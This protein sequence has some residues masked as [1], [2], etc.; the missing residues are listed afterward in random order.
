M[1]RCQGCMSHCLQTLIGQST[2]LA[3]SSRASLRLGLKSSGPSPRRHA[4]SPTYR[5][6]D[7]GDGHPSTFRSSR[8]RVAHTLTKRREYSGSEDGEERRPRLPKAERE[9]GD[10][11]AFM[12]TQNRQEWLDSRGTT[13]PNKK[14]A[15]TELTEH[16]TARDAKRFLVRKILNKLA[17]PLQL[18]QYVRT[19]LAKEDLDHALEIVRTA[20]KDTQCTVSWNHIIEW[21]LLKQKL[22]TALKTYHEVESL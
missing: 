22:R 19:T 16:D 1:L 9:K 3:S 14:L 15:T 18:A 17:D 10:S 20:S 5:H 7:D 11:K 4:S 8:D 2:P 13:P 21:L 12:R 6:P